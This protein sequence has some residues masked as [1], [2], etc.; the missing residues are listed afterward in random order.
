VSAIEPA[1]REEVADFLCSSA[2]YNVLRVDGKAIAMGS[3]GRLGERT[4][5]MLQVAEGADQHI[6]RL[7]RALRDYFQNRNETV[8][9]ICG[10]PALPHAERLLTLIGFA[11]IDEWVADGKRIWRWN[12]R[13][14]AV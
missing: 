12:T 13:E 11:P 4:W 5:V 6:I 8:H 2:E 7:V 10:A 9:A 3:I 1:T 14:A